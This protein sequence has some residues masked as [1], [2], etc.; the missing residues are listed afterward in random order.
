VKI[1]TDPNPALVEK[2]GVYGLPTVMLFKGG[3][4]VEGSKREG[5]LSRD[6]PAGGAHLAFRKSACREGR[7]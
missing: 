4:A 5:A 1:E 3:A 7:P 2:Y 6:P